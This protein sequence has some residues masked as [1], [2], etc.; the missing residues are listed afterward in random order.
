MSMRINPNEDEGPANPE[1]LP[2][3]MAPKDEWILGINQ[4]FK[5]IYMI[6]WKATCDFDY[7]DWPPW[8]GWFATNSLKPVDVTHFIRAPWFIDAKSGQGWELAK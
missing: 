5:A 4:D 6:K 2:I 7:P 1:P 8:G 3:A